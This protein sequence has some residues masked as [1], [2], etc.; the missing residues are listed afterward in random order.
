MA[1]DLSTPLRDYGELR[2]GMIGKHQIRNASTAVRAAEV[3]LPGRRPGKDV[4]RKGLAEA[5]FAGRFQVLNGE[6][7]VILDVSHNEEAL[8]ASLD[9]LLKLSPPVR[10]VIVFGV[11]A[12]K[13][14]GRFPARAMRAARDIIL[15]PLKEK[16]AAG[17]ADLERRFGDAADGRARASVRPVRGMAGAMRLAGR[18]A[19]P[20]DTILILGSHLAVEEAVARM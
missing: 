16:G 9:T 19:G 18:L 4:V 7:R 6:P 11:M 14:L 1:F 8:C 17:A 10:N 3:F 20:G 12:R 13:K 5:S 2:T 15:V